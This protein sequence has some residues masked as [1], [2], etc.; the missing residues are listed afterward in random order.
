[1][2]DGPPVDAH[3]LTSIVPHDYARTMARGG[4]AGAVD[5]FAGKLFTTAD[6]S[7]ATAIREVSYGQPQVIRVHSVEG[8]ADGDVC[9]YHDVQPGDEAVIHA[10]ASLTRTAADTYRLAANA[11]VTVE[12]A[13]VVSWRAAG[14]EWQPAEGAIPA[15]ADEVR[16]GG[17]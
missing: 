6:G 10:S 9:W 7:A 1:V 15:S 13:G 4:Q 2:L 5:F 16:I 14:G 17:R 8:F 3:T 12:A 11:P